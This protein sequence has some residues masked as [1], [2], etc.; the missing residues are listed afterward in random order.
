M[1]IVSDVKCIY[2]AQDVTSFHIRYENEDFKKLQVLWYINNE[3]G[4][5]KSSLV[6]LLRSF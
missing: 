5:K 2:S 6:S 4:W 3:K 1:K